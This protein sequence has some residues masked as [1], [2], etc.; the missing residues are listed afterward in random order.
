MLITNRRVS[1]NVVERLRG[2]DRQ[3][4]FRTAIINGDQFTALLGEHHSVYRRHFGHARIGMVGS[5]PYATARSDRGDQPQ[6]DV[7]FEDQRAG[8]S[9]GCKGIIDPAATLSVI[10]R[11]VAAALGSLTSSVRTVRSVDGTI[12][13]MRAV[14]VTLHIGK[15]TLSDIEVLVTDTPVTLIGANVLKHLT[16]VFDGPNG[17]VRIWPGL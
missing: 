16:T 5:E 14:F 1:Q 9:V 6:I 13:Q 15:L 11:E 7:I 4:P 17:T 3:S 2:I 10:P 8:Q 12:L